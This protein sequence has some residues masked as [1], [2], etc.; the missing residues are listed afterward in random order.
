MRTFSTYNKVSGI[1]ILSL[2]ASNKNTELVAHR[3]ELI[4]SRIGKY[5]WLGRYSSNSTPWIV[6]SPHPP[7]YGFEEVE[8]NINAEYE[9]FLPINRVFRTGN[10]GYQTHRDEFVIDFVPE[11]VTSRIASFRKAHRNEDQLAEQ[12]GVESNRDWSL[13]LAHKTLVQDTNWESRIQPTL[14]RPFDLRY[15]AYV[16]FDRL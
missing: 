3:Y 16:P 2:T 6:V 13:L 9:A 1:T 14:Y 12:F 15:I 7:L 11:S 8:H 4:G 10:V 5:S